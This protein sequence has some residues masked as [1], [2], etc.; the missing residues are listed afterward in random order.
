MQ[1]CASDAVLHQKYLIAYHVMCVTMHHPDVLAL[2]LIMH[3]II[4]LR[5]VFTRANLY[6]TYIHYV[7]Q[8]NA[9]TASGYTLSLA[10]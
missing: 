8:T 9:V 7:E 10:P 1:R 4:M 3:N 6:R 2:Q 5:T